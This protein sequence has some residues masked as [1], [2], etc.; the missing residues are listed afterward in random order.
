MAYYVADENSSRQDAFTCVHYRRLQPE[1]PH[2]RTEQ[3]A[4]DECMDRHELQH[5]VPL[6]EARGV[7]LRGS[8]TLGGTEL[9]LEVL[10]DVLLVGVRALVLVVEDPLEGKG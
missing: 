1:C 7:H 4:H 5:L 8:C 3:K 9:A 10:L 6:V 2:D